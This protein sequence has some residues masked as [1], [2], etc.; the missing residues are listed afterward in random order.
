MRGWLT[1]K[2]DPEFENKCAEVCTLSH[3]A[4]A[5]AQQAL[6]P[7]TR[8]CQF[9]R[10]AVMVGAAE[11]RLMRSNFSTRRKRTADRRQH[12]GRLE[13]DLRIR[14]IAA[15]RAQ[16]GPVRRTGRAA[17]RR[18]A[19]PVGE[20][21]QWIEQPIEGASPNRARR[22][23]RRRAGAERRRRFEYRI[24]LASGQRVKIARLGANPAPCRKPRHEASRKAGRGKSAR[25][26]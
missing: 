25:P 4:P 1:P 24:S 20:A 9:S 10:N 11:R 23:R 22:L 16:R 18:R 8:S 15:A 7:Q 13:A 12:E 19:R 5:A 26:V 3:E 17:T 21:F 6:S 14:G 2:P